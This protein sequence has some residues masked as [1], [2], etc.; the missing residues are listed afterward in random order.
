MVNLCFFFYWC[1]VASR[2]RPTLLH[3]AQRSAAKAV[4]S[5]KLLAPRA[6]IDGDKPHL[7]LAHPWREQA[8]SW[9]DYFFPE[10]LRRMAPTTTANMYSG[11]PSNPELWHGRMA[12]VPIA[13]HIEL[14][15]GAN[16][17]DVVSS[18]VAIVRCHS[19]RV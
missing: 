11:D 3:M 4:S 10:L 14:R 5:N 13:G 18:G 1:Q 19:R 12:G 16:G 15:E 9:T 2:I 6:A 7:P 17:E 8:N